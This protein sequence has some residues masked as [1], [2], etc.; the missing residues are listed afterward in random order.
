MGRTA[1]HFNG[2]PAETGPSEGRA[3]IRR[4]RFASASIP[5]PLPPVL[6]DV[7]VDGEQRQELRVDGGLVAQLRI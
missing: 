5:G 2:A 4:V 6:F 1:A 3:A 7:K